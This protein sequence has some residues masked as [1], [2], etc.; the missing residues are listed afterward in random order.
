MVQT[1]K[2]VDRDGHVFEIELYQRE[3]LDELKD[4]IMR[5]NDKLNAAWNNVIKLVDHKSPEWEVAMQKWHRANMELHFYCQ[6]LEQLDY[7]DCLYIVDGKKT[8]KCID[9]VGDE[10]GCRV[11]PSW[12]DYWAE[13]LLALPSGGD[14]VAKKP[15]PVPAAQSI[16]MGGLGI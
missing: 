12:R 11:C 1:Y 3:R 15:A 4:R 2:A 16:P 9:L 7:N 10:L 13:E 14:K 5:G 8:R 6:Q